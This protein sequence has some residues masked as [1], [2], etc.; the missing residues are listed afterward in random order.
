MDVCFLMF[1]TILW[2]SIMPIMAD[3]I[4]SEC[5]AIFLEDVLYWRESESWCGDM[6]TK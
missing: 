6:Q 4:G 2:L 1:S 5:L 3:N